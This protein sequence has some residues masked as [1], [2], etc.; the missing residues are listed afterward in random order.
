MGKKKEL[1][2]ARKALA[3]LKAQ[4][5]KIKMAEGEVKS[6]CFH[7]DPKKDN[8][9]IKKKKKDG[10]FKC[11][12]CHSKIDFT[13]FGNLDTH[14]TKKYV[15]STIGNYIN[16]IDIT[17]L[18]LNKKNKKDEKFVKALIIAA[19]S[20]YRFKK[21]A[22]ASIADMFEPHKKGKKKKN[23]KGKGYNKVFGGGKSFKGK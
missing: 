7:K 3:S 9:Y 16:L 6:E 22:V 18:M 19:K 2:N 10:V 13:P 17:K 1:S 21:I 14:E 23:K 4:I 8:L 15:K 5:R 20:A 12:E 11:K